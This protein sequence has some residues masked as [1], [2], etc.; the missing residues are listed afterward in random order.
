MDIGIIATRYA[1]ALLA[2]ATENKQEDTVYNEMLALCGSFAKVPN[3][4]QVLINP[5][6]SPEKKETLLKAASLPQDA[7]TSSGVSVSLSRFV[8]LVVEHRRSDMMQF[9]A[10]SYVSAYRKAKQLISGRLILAGAVSEDVKS[11]LREVIEQKSGGQL[12]FEVVLNPDILGGFVLEYDTYRLDASL[13]T[14][15]DQLRR[16]LK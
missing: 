11:H 16:E 6:L 12:D 7:Q 5:V 13:R 10:H 2:Y 8:H 9:I 15:L 14:Q 3:L 1:K 4:G